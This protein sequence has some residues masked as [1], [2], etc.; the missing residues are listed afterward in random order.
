MGLARGRLGS[1]SSLDVAD[2][3]LLSFPAVLS[4]VD[5]EISLLV[6]MEMH[7]EYCT[8]RKS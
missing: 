8:S 3:D 6:T 1:A 5:G 4:S 2:V 7:D